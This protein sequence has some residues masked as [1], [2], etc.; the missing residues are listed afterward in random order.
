MKDYFRY[1]PSSLRTRVWGCEL[2][3]IGRTR[4]H[5]GAPYPPTR[6]PDDHHFH[7]E[8]GRVLQ[9]MQIVFIAEGR[10]VLESTRPGNSV[11]L[12]SG[13]VFILFPG[14]WHRFAPDSATGWTEHWIEIAGRACDAVLSANLLT[15]S[16]SVISLR[17][18]SEVL[19]IFNRL[20][21]FCTSN[22]GHDAAAT[23]ALH[24]A[25]RLV[26]MTEQ[27]VGR[28]TSL[29]E[30]LQRARRLLN[31]D[32]ERPFDAHAVASSV[33]LGVSHFRQTFRRECGVAPRT[34]HAEARLRRAAD[35]LANT[36]MST[37]EIADLLGFS[38]PFHFSHAFKRGR[39]LAPSHWRDSQ[40]TR[41][42]G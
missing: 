4:I 11:R 30:R 35:L 15:P 8:R 9:R 22:G 27:P 26:E 32:C 24:L 25:S 18:P 29:R 34:F 3:A 39:G 6:H 31:D 1:Y 7:W 5:P 19:H 17:D 40:G 14:V 21:A 13:T 38:S 33:G 12:G 23:L 10:G 16:N 36:D 37:K 2:G 42:C 28:A 20:H 41:N